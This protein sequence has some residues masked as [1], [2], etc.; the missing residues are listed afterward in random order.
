MPKKNKGTIKWGQKDR[1]DENNEKAIRKLLADAD[2]AKK[3]WLE[4]PAEW[5]KANPFIPDP[6]LGV[7]RITAWPSTEWFT[8]ATPSGRAIQVRGLNMAVAHQVAQLCKQ[9]KQSQADS[10]TWP[11]VIVSL[12][13]PTASSQTGEILALLDPEEVSQFADLGFKVTGSKALDDLFERPEAAGG[14]GGDDV[15]FDDI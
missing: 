6:L 13:E 11:T 8:I 5:R 1:A 10:G 9:C 4:K 3:E 2:A 7:A 15:D 12:P 14:G